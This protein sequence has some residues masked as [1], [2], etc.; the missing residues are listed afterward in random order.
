MTQV[1]D[2]FL[3][4]RK[5]LSSNASTSNTR[6]KAMYVLMGGLGT[7]ESKQFKSLSNLGC[8]LLMAVV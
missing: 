2:C 6:R 7:F 8:F 3:S 5:T 4:K 1:I